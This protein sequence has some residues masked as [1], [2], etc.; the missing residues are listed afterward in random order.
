MSDD[1][2]V[3]KQALLDDTKNQFL[4]IAIL[5]FF[6]GVNPWFWSKTGNFIFFCL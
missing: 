2:L 3:Q 5:K 4:I 6:K 1:H